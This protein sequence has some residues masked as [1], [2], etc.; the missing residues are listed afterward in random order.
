MNRGSIGSL[1]GGSSLMAF[2][3]LS[4][5]AGSSRSANGVRRSSSCFHSSS[6]HCL[7]L[8]AKAARARTRLGNPSERQKA[9]RCSPQAGC[10]TMFAVLA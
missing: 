2:F 9:G 3:G 4:F 7:T 6:L 5:S 8:L 10:A 1:S